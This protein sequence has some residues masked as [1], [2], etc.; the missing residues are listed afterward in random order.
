MANFVA[1][2][3]SCFESLRDW[4]NYWLDYFLVHIESEFE[5]LVI[6]RKFFTICRER[7]LFLSEKKCTLFAKQEKWCGRL[8]GDN[9]IQYDPRRLEGLKDA[10]QPTTASELCQLVCCLQW[11]SMSI[12]DFSKRVE[13][14]RFILE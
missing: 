14:L 1:A 8:I 11:M 7:G 2:V 13:P 3:G 4:T 12:P 6:L 10:Q 5:L 9:G